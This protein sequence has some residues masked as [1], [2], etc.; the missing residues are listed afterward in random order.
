MRWDPRLLIAR[1]VKR[2]DFTY[3]TLKVA[4]RPA[5]RAAANVRVAG[6]HHVPATGPAILAANHVSVLDSLYVPLVVPRRITYLAK[7]E[8]W[9]SWRTRWILDAAGHIPVRRGRV[10]SARDALDNAG[11]LLRSG[12]LL[13]VYPEGTRSPDGRLHRGKTGVAVLAARSGCPVVPIGIAGTAALVPKGTK[14]PRRRGHVVVRFGAPLWI[15]PRAGSHQR[16]RFLDALMTE[17]AALSGQRYDRRTP[18]QDERPSP[19][20]LAV[21]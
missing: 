18:D 10:A 11:Q 7:A 4:L 19:V 9:D 8:Y 5:L 6:L 16:R 17:I 12:G 2:R 20:S 14:L 1:P 13:G 15:E 3:T 21:S